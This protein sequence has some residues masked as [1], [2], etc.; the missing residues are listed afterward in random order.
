MAPTRVPL[1]PENHIDTPS[2]FDPPSHLLR[3]LRQV[4]PRADLHCLGDGR[5]VVGVV[6][7]TEERCMIG[8]RMLARY[9]NNPEATRSEMRMAYLHRHGLGV[10][11]IYERDELGNCVADFRRMDAQFSPARHEHAVLESEQQHH[12][13]SVEE[14]IEQVRLREKDEW[15]RIFRDRSHFV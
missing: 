9:T 5:W 14:M 11:G 1:N 13:D 2:V 12:T 8:G 3:G 10:I 6:E 4:D 15:G 7:P